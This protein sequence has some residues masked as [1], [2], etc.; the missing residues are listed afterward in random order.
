MP[1]DPKEGQL[2][3]QSELQGEPKGEPDS[4]DQGS[5]P[6]TQMIIQTDQAL[7]SIAQ[8]LAKASPDAAKA[9]AQV[10]E[11]FRQII[12]SVM[13]QGQGQPGQPPQGGGQRPASPMVSPETQGKP[14]MMAY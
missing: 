9:M 10:N 11:Q 3:Q 1:Q 4:A 5:G 7:T 14:A 12:Q 13:G 6:L 2:D 8:V